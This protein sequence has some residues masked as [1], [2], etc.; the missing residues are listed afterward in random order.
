MS[1]PITIIDGTT[2]FDAASVNKFISSDGLAVSVKMFHARIFF[3]A[4][5]LVVSSAIDSA[6]ILTAD[7]AFVGGTTTVNIT[8]AGYTNPPV[9]LC[10]PFGDASYTTKPTAV[11]NVLASINFF[12]IDT[13]AKIVTGVL[14]VNMDFMVTTIG[15]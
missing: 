5:N 13:G 8:L 15:F 12:N 2:P 9:V 11:T 4:V 14:D 3:D 10:T 7:T 1:T 6:G